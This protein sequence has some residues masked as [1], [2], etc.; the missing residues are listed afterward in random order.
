M[1][2]TKDFI[3]KVEGITSKNEIILVTMDVSSLYTNI[4]NHE[5]IVS[6]IE[7]IGPW[8]DKKVNLKSLQKLLKAVL[9]KNNFE[10]NAKCYLQIGDTA[11]GTGLAYSYSN[12]FMGKLEKRLLHEAKIMGIS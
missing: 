9:H 2:D 1:K 5:G 11:M 7:I 10:F 12:I 8:Y 4:P 6:V 3:N